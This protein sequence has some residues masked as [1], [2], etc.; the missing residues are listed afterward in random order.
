MALSMD[1][2]HR[3]R[4]M[5]FDRYGRMQPAAMLDI[6]Q[7][8]AIAHAEE[9]GIGRAA[10]LEKNVVW[11]VIRTKLQVLQDPTPGEVV[12]VHT[13]PHSLSRFSFIRDFSMRNEAGE[14]L[15][16]AT[17]EWVLMDF[18]TRKFCSAKD[19]YTGPHD[20]EEARAFG[21]RPRKLKDFDA[22]GAPALIIVPRFADI[23]V[24][25]HVN[26]AVYGDYVVNA[27]NP[28]PEGAI[29]TFQIDYRHEALPGEPL[30]MFVHE[31]GGVV[32]VKAVNPRGEV[33][34][35]SAIEPR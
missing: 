4:W 19:A 13:W 18:D 15:V 6:F 3:L 10:M 27:L 30:E 16:K 7:D 28:G 35:A 14:E 24:N 2:K 9:L 17:Q 22:E 20:F 23:D 21:K 34:F 31:D 12:N 33:A 25:G 29:G 8:L 32:S 26:N 5:D 11:V 1:R